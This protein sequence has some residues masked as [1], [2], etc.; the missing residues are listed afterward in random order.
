M[1][2]RPPEGGREDRPLV[3]KQ[4]AAAMITVGMV[5]VAGSVGA[6]EAEAY[7]LLQGVCCAGAG[8]ALVYAG[9]KMTEGRDKD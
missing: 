8:F 4:V 5:L 7:S 9:R 1:R 2:Q 6:C 3:R